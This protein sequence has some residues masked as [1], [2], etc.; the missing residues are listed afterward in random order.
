MKGTILRH[1]GHE[2]GSPT[3]LP[4]GAPRPG[5]VTLREGDGP[6]DTQAMLDPANQSLSE[7]LNILLKLI[8][9]GVFVLCIVY[10][11]SGLRRVQENERGVRLLFG[12]VVDGDLSPGLQYGPPFPF[13]EVVRVDQS[14]EDVHIRRPFWPFIQGDNA[15]DPNGVVDQSVDK[16]APTQSLKPDQ[17]GSGS[18]ITG[19]GNIVHA[20]WKV[21]YKRVNASTYAANMLPEDET[22]LVMAAV[23]RGAVQATAEATIDGVLSANQASLA[24]VAKQVAQD[25]LDRAESG[26]VIDSLSM[27]EVTPPLWVRKNFQNVQSAVAKKQQEE[28]K[29]STEAAAT[30]N[31]VAGDAAPYLV[32][33]IDAYEKALATGNADAGDAILEGM[34]KVMGGE[35]VDFG[36]SSRRASGEVTSL[37]ADAGAYR[38]EVVSGAK[39]SLAR[40]QVMHE[41][42]QQNPMLMLQREWGGA[43]TAFT[44]RRTVTQMFLPPGRQGDL[45]QVL[46]NQDPTIARDI[47]REVNEN[48]ARRAQEAQL[49]RQQTEGLK[50]EIRDA[51]SGE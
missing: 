45:V 44:G 29:A 41:Q 25:T 10:A 20:R 51:V 22:Q 21:Q 1:D 3:P 39:S 15:N 16:L 23:Q 36:G 2:G 11:F 32:S 14:V 19:D 18:L 48:Q 46:I 9:F 24:A 50:T 35:P 17:G 38:A 4:G 6:A 47:E 7:A 12:K 49:R 8:Y 30:L 13:G 27:T 43:V 31:R 28:E 40:F 26:I 37:I 33:Q 5:S 42:F 34:R